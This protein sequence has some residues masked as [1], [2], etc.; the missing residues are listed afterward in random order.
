M[1]VGIA[2]IGGLIS[3]IVGASLTI[4]VYATIGLAVWLLAWW[5]N[6]PRISVVVRT[7]LTT[8]RVWPPTYNDIHFEGEEDEHLAVVVGGQRLRGAEAA[9]FLSGFLS[10][11]NGPDCVDVSVRKAVRR[12]TAAERI[13]LG[14]V[15]R[16]AEPGGSIK[17]AIAEARLAHLRPWEIIASENLHL[18]LVAF[19]PESRVALEMAATEEAEQIDLSRQ[20]REMETSVRRERKVAAIADDLLLPDEIQRKLVALRLAEGRDALDP[21]EQVD[22]PAETQVSTLSENQ[23]PMPT[24][25]QPPTTFEE[26]IAPFPARVRESATTLRTLILE[27]MPEAQ[28]SVSGGQS[29]GTALYSLVTP[30]NV[31]CGLQPASSHCKLYLHHLQPDDAAGLKL[32]GS[33]KNVRHVKV[34]SPEAAQQVEIAAA[35][36]RAWLRAGVK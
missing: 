6:P 12:V 18:N 17:R 4:T 31:A 20:A 35:I 23:Y 27:A 26:L 3:A 25:K 10:Q 5:R 13:S 15:Y 29:F 34:H 21:D 1:L 8:L 7:P 28:E 11:I 2:A 24:Y 14:E 16:G 33:G 32:E 22:H 9:M 36:A 19:D 30:T